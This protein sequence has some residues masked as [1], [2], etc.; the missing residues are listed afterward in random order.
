MTIAFFDLDRTVLDI[1]SG[2]A[3]VRYER[4]AG[5]IGWT[6]LARATVW[7]L[8]YHLGSARLDGALRLAIRSLAGQPE[9][10]LTERTLHFWQ[11]RVQAHVRPAAREALAR[12]RALGHRLVL[13]TT[14]SNYLSAPAGEALGLDAWLCNRFEVGPD[15]RFTGEPVE[16][17]C[18]AEGKVTHARRE[19]E[20]H[21]ADLADC[22]FYS[23]SASDLAMLEAVGH[24]VVVTPDPKLRRIAVA[25]GWPIEDWSASSR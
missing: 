1:N 14:S 4:E 8:R 19:A 15:G 22:W 16:P 9:A 6:Q 24:P 18:F 7:L 20:A 10:E 12:H 13:L 5:R 2:S 17:L 25:R 3:W 11:D 23:D 21:G